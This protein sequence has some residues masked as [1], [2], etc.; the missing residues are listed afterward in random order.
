MGS[1]FQQPGC[2]TWSIQYYSLH[3][4]RVRESTGTTDFETAQKKLREKLHAIDKGEPIEPRRRQQV[5]CG[6][7]YLEVVRDYTVQGRKSRKDLARRWRHLK[8]TFENRA[9]RNVNDEALAAYVDLRL[10]EK[11]ANAT[12]NREL[13]C[14]KRA[15]RIGQPKHKYVLPLFPHLKED[16]VRT[17][18]VEQEAFDR[19]RAAATE[20]WLRLWLEI[21]FEYGWRRSE[22]MGLRVRQ[23]NPTTGLI[24]LDVGAT[25]NDDGREVVMTATIRELVRLAI[26]GKQPDDFLITRADGKAIRD[27]R[28]LW[29]SLCV[30]AGLGRWV[31]R[32]CEK[33]VTGEKCECGEKKL[34]YVGLIRHDFRRSA[35]RELRRAGVAESTI[36]DIGGWKTRSMFDRYAIKDPRDIK[37]AIEKREEQ[38][39]QARVDA[40]AESSRHQEREAAEER[41]AAAATRAVQ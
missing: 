30:K 9:A 28:K 40:R 22:P 14:L 38:R 41:I 25:K 4:K 1:V 6:E 36:M 10:S 34:K 5:T 20:L 2:S 27:F 19:L 13:A 3:G 24:R 37:A 23:A 26:D 12:I 33:T 35:A 11:A 15:L 32:A 8:P 21:S 29:Y 39:E 7:L 18:F 16:N 17:G 31:C